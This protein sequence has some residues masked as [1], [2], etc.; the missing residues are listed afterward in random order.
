MSGYG[1]RRQILQ[2]AEK[3]SA[4][5][6]FHEG[7]LRS[8]IE[9]EAPAEFPLGMVRAREPPLQKLSDSM[10]RLE[11]VTDLFCREAS[12]RSPDAE[13]RLPNGG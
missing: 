12:V 6:R 11:V 13:R 9:P 8:D 3:L 4:D 7:R 2:A 10:R 5:R 1:R